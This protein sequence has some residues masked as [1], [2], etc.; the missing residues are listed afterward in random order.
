MWDLM[1][2][3][4]D[5]KFGSKRSVEILKKKLRPGSVIVLHDSPEGTTL[6]FIK[7]FL[8]FALAEGYRFDLS[9]LLNKQK[10]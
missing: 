4:F 7:D 8:S 2:Y 5:K 6:D 3:D 1:P 9:G 10:V